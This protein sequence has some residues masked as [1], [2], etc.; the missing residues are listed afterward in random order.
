MAVSLRLTRCGGKKKPFYRLIATDSRMPR[1]GRFI[2]II[3]YYNP[4]SEPSTVEIDAEKAK[5][6]LERGAQP[7]AIVKKLFAITGI[8]KLEKKIKKP[9]ARTLRARETA[10]K[11]A[12][13]KTAE[14]V[15]APVEAP[16]ATTG[17]EAAPVEE[18][19]EAAVA[20]TPAEPPVNVESTAEEEVGSPTAAAETETETTAEEF[21]E[22]FKQTTAVN[23]ADMSSEQT[24]GETIKPEN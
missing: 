8:I 6:W 23:E 20:E 19:G 9:G 16:V 7:T 12:E 18:R 21:E 4:R 10:K 15:A 17:V 13:K 1:D 22:T 2:E 24:P 5:F 11:A 3:G 14:E